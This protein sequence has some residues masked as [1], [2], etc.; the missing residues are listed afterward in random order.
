MLLVSQTHIAF[1]VDV[2]EPADLIKFQLFWLILARDHASP[3][4][5][6]F[7]FRQILNN[8]RYSSI[9]CGIKTFLIIGWHDLAFN[10]VTEL[11][12]AST[13]VL[14][15]SDYYCVCLPARRQFCNECPLV[16]IG[17]IG[18]SSCLKLPLYPPQWTKI[19]L[20]QIVKLLVYIRR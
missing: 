12:D 6:I 14:H 2:L 7:C 17:H 9:N 4:K 1:H 11:P 10:E 13:L 18:S 5:T 19:L 16:G 3:Y 15:E 20:S 8:F